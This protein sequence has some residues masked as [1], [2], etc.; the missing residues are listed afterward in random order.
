MSEYTPIE[1]HLGR[2]NIL[3]L[4]NVLKGSQ[5][6]HTKGPEY[7]AGYDDMRAEAIGEL[8]LMWHSAQIATNAINEKLSADLADLDKQA[9]RIERSGRPLS[10]LAGH[11]RAIAAVSDE[12]D[13]LEEIDES[14][15]AEHRATIARL[16]G[17]LADLDA[18]LDDLADEI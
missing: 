14:N 15:N 11:A 17:R 2:L 16:I 7:V 12:L 18:A 10:V 6:D 5:A 3:Q 1:P 4:L 9:D 13:A 8:S